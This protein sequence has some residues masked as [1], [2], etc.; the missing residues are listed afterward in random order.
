MRYLTVK[1]FASESGYTEDAVRS[2][3]RDGIWR[4]GEIWKKAPDGRT[5]IDVEGYEAWVEMGG[6]SGRSLIRV[7]KSRSCIAAS[8]A[9]SAS[10]SSPPPLT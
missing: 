4:L 1:K 3:I 9:G 7:S 10:R 2:K 6:E 5:L 8:G